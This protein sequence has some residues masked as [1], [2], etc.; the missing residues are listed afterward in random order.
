MCCKQSVILRKYY[1]WGFKKYI[2]GIIAATLLTLTLK[3]KGIP[4][5][6]FPYANA[7][8][9]DCGRY[10]KTALELF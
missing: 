10:Y 5:A 4:N 2:S 1:K 8:V 9:Q 6:L 3:R 7:T